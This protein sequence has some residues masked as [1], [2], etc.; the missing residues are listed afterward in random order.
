MI[1]LYKSFLSP[2]K[3]IYRH[4]TTLKWQEKWNWNSEKKRVFYVVYDTSQHSTFYI[5]FVLQLSSRRSELYLLSHKTF[6]FLSPT[7]LIANKILRLQEMKF[8]WLYFSM[9][10][11]FS[12]PNWQKKKE[13]IL[14]FLLLK[15]ILVLLFLLLMLLPQQRYFEKKKKLPNICTSK[16]KLY[17]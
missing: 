2:R 9:L 17:I 12:V 8:K 1:N 5:V 4:V 14:Q 3:L 11:P 6:L 10:L 15:F 13:R 7:P 16:G